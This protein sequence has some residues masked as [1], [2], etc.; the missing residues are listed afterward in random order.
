MESWIS[1]DAHNRCRR[2]LYC[3]LGHPFKVIDLRIIRTISCPDIICDSSLETI[4]S[5][6]ESFWCK[7]VTMELAWYPRCCSLSD[8]V[9]VINRKKW[10]Y[11]KCT[12]AN[13]SGYQSKNDRYN[14]QLTIRQEQKSK[15]SQESRGCSEILL[16][17]RWSRRVL[18]NG[19]YSKR[20]RTSG[21]LR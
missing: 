11:L 8:Q 9:F 15:L 18:V 20:W 19:V 16:G 13:E 17:L 10:R 2:L 14:Q 5:L 12:W 6:L 3:G 4:H 1:M 21:R 7:C